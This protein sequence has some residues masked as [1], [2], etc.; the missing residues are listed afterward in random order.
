MSDPSLGQGDVHFKHYNPYELPAD[1]FAYES[2]L[3]NK[4]VRLDPSVPIPD[5]TET[6]AMSEIQRMVDYHADMGVTVTDP[7]LE[8]GGGGTD[9]EFSGFSPTSNQCTSAF[10]FTIYGQN[11][12]IPDPDNPG[13]YLSLVQYLFFAN[14]PADEW[15]PQ[16]FGISSDPPPADAAYIMVTS[17]STITPTEQ[18][19]NP[20]GF[21]VDPTM[22]PFTFYVSPMWLPADKYGSQDEND[23]LWTDFAAKFTDTGVDLSGPAT[24]P[25]TGGTITLTAGIGDLTDQ[26]VNASWALGGSTGAPSSWTLTSPTTI[27]VVFS[28]FTAVVPGAVPGDVV[29]IQLYFGSQ[30]YSN[31]VNVTLT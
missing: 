31:A 21:P 25:L 5:P 14:Y 22:L 3:A 17:P 28:D 23:L 11:M 30:I 18:L 27:D 20:P 26:V 12:A 16:T 7:R 15:L 6:A 9:A 29:S 2:F 4:V 13:Q 8:G 1:T 19:F 24:M 10:D